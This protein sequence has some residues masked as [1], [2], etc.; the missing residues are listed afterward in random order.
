MIEALPPFYY[1]EINNWGDM[2]PF[3]LTCKDLY[4]K[5]GPK[6]QRLVIIA[7]KFPFLLQEQ[8]SHPRHSMRNYMERSR[9]WRID[10][11]RYNDKPRVFKIFLTWLIDISEV[12]EAETNPIKVPNGSEMGLIYECRN[13]IRASK[14][15]INFKY[16]DFFIAFRD[17]L[18][19]CHNDAR[20]MYLFERANRYGYLAYVARGEESF[21]HWVQKSL[22]FMEAFFQVLWRTHTAPIRKWSPYT[23]IKVVQKG[24]TWAVEYVEIEDYNQRIFSEESWP[25]MQLILQ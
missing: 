2:L 12:N 3:Y 7:R 14:W 21:K 25:P 22:P 17:L 15:T 4:A 9:Q 19:I 8:K 11:D 5:Y 18:W 1:N 6:D 16:C 23:R 13:V 20:R 10:N 24:Y